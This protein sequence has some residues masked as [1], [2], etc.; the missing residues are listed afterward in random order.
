MSLM[1][2]DE[3]FP[4]AESIR[5]ELV[6]SHMPP[7]N[8]EDGFG[9]L[10]RAHALSSKELDIIMTWASGGNPR[11][12]LDQKLPEVT[13]KNEWAMGAPDLALPLPSEFTVAAD[14]MEDTQEFTLATGLDRAAL[15][16]GRRPAAR[17]AIHRPQRRHLREGRESAAPRRLPRRTMCWRAGC[18]DRTPSRSTPA[19]RSGCP[20]E[21]S[22]WRVFTTRRRGSSKASRWPIAARSACTSRRAGMRGNS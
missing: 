21:R 13:L 11:G 12:S 8:A 20:P 15:G 16:A 4:W 10:K 19:P 9:E 14:K 22:S 1:T 5:A 6:A 3:A 17:D 18:R 7:W 2:Y